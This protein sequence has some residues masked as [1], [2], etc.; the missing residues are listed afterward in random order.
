[1]G[2]GYSSEGGKSHARR[3]SVRSEGVGEF[4]SDLMKELSK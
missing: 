3:A 4:R 1:M 2:S